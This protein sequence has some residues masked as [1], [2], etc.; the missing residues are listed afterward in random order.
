M[1]EAYEHA[2]E[3]NVAAHVVSDFKTNRYDPASG[4]LRFT[5][6]QAHAFALAERHYAE[7]FAQPA[8]EMG[9]VPSAVE[10]RQ[11]LQGVYA[12]ARAGTSTDFVSLAV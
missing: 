10:I 8:T 1:T 4:T 9:D 7:F 3:R 5:A 2:G 11:R 12:T 6:A